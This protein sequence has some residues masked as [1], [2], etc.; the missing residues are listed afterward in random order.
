MRI[1]HSTYFGRIP[2]RANAWNVLLWMA[3][4]CAAAASSAPAPSPAP[5]KLRALTGS[6]T[7]DKVVIGVTRTGVVPLRPAYEQRLKELQALAIAGKEVVSNE[8][9]CVPSGPAMDMV[10]GFQSLANASELVVLMGGPVIRHIWVD[11]RAHPR[12]GLQFGAFEGDSIGHWEGDSLVVDTVGLKP[13][14]EIILG[15][16]ADDDQMRL[17]ERWHLVA[18]D[19]LQIETT[20]NNPK[21]LLRPWTFKRQFSRVEATGEVSYCTP[22][23]DRTR[24]GGFDL[25]PP[26]G[27]YV[28]PGAAP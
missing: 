23:I 18:P 4:L 16:A 6:W 17:T 27:G 8:S 11:G 12:E 20:V 10:F 26:A 19:Q 21:V 9:K 24:D 14:D 13:T 1:V 2:V 28:P 25:T 22:S 7:N 15:I 3:T 5:E